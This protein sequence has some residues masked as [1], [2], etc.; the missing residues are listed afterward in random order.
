[1]T[2]QWYVHDILQPHVLILMQRLPRAIFQQDN[3]RP[4]TARMSQYCLLTI[5]TLL[6]LPDP[7]IGLQSSISGIIWNGELGIP[8][9]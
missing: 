7:Q 3:V 9:V 6:G 5:T 1:M 4:H 2:A 8:R